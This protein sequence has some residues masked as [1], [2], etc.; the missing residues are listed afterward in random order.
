MYY[1]NFLQYKS[2]WIVWI[3]F[4]EWSIFLRWKWD[5]YIFKP[6]FLYVSFI[7]IGFTWMKRLY[8]ELPSSWSKH[9]INGYKSCHQYIQL[10]LH[11]K[12]LKSIL[13]LFK[14]F[15]LVSKQFLFRWKMYK[16]IFRSIVSLHPKNTY[17]INWLTSQLQQSWDYTFKVFITSVQNKLELIFMFYFY[18]YWYDSWTLSSLQASTTLPC[19]STKKH[20]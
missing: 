2:I 18:V 20:I 17:F 7:K 3:L 4:P 15:P 19:N 11:I 9:K 8:E 1:S 16:N 5:R 10:I 14:L 6:N 13:V 12:F